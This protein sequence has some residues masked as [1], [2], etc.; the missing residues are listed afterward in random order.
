MVYQRQCLSNRKSNAAQR[1]RSPSLHRHPP[2]PAPSS[3]IQLV[4]LPTTTTTAPSH[5]PSF[6]PRLSLVMS[7]LSPYKTRAE[8]FFIHSLTE[9]LSPMPRKPKSP[10]PKRKRSPEPDRPPEPLRSPEIPHQE[11]IPT[12]P[13]PNK[14][15]YLPKSPGRHSESPKLSTARFWSDK[16]E[17]LESPRKLRRDSR[18]NSQSI[19]PGS[20]PSK[21]VS[22]C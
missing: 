22:S 3:Y 15:Q 18:F 13:A 8:E 20:T 5:A 16:A 7:D 14:F 11:I 2:Q 10:R 9:L 4:D 17:M 12:T 21:Q 6:P 19:S 1:G